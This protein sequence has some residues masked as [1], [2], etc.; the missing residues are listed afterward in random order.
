MKD[1]LSALNDSF[2]GP[3]LVISFSDAIEINIYLDIVTSTPFSVFMALESSDSC[4]NYQVL[5]RLLCSSDCTYTECPFQYAERDDQHAH[6]Q[7]CRFK[8]QSTTKV[9]IR[10][11]IANHMKFLPPNINIIE[12][13]AMAI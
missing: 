8:C 10:C 6:I 7:Y 4:Q 13:A 11:I 5:S 3:G 2:G 1:A 12:L 9:Y